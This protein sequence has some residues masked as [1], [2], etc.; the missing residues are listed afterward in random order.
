MCRNTA[1]VV[2]LKVHVLQLLMYESHN[3]MSL[4]SCHETKVLTQLEFYHVAQ[5]SSNACDIIFSAHNKFLACDVTNLIYCFLD[6]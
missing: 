3:L 6:P 4:F 2:K 1:K 5:H